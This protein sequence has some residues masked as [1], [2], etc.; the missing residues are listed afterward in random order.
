LKGAIN[1]A[2]QKV[3][4]ATTMFNLGRASNLD[5]TDAREALID[6]KTQYMRRVADYYTQLGVIESLTGLPLADPVR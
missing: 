5:I 3:D 2:E 6:S 1:A 4:F